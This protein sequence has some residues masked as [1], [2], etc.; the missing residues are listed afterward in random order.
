[1]AIEDQMIF[2]RTILQWASLTNQNAQQLWIDLW[3][4][5]VLKLYLIMSSV[6]NLEFLDQPL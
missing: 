3:E 2:T 5:T 6:T 1:M 4:E